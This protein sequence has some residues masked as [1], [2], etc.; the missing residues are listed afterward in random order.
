V[1]RGYAPVIEYLIKPVLGGWFELPSGS[2]PYVP[3]TVSHALGIDRLSANPS[4]I[5]G[6]CEV[7]ISYEDPGVQVTFQGPIDPVLAER[8][9]REIADKITEISGQ[10]GRVLQIS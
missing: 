4:L 6:D 8:V 1:L 5:I 3:R 7:T 2:N 10:A 9:V